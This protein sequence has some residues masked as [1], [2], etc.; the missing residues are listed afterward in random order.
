MDTNINNLRQKSKL[1]QAKLAMINNDTHS[2]AIVSEGTAISQLP[3]GK[4]TGNVSDF[5]DLPTDGLPLNES[6]YVTVD[7]QYKKRI[8]VD[9][10][11]ADRLIFG[12]TRSY[13]DKKVHWATP[14][15]M[16]NIP[17][18]SAFTSDSFVNANLVMSPGNAYLEIYGQLN[19][20]NQLGSTSIYTINSDN[21]LINLLKKYTYDQVFDLNY[22][23]CPTGD[24]SRA[25]TA[26]LSFTQYGNLKVVASGNWN[27]LDFAITVPL[28][29]KTNT[30]LT[31][32]SAFY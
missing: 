21:T 10:R 29:V 11:N 19:T 28:V 15:Q 26:N 17:V 32:H 1:L 12:T 30:N 3:P 22:A 8:I 27:N 4:Y 7:G 6:V 14:I 5:T 9:V 24:Q 23:I 2:I 18:S 20:I 16:V 25:I 13:D 31:N